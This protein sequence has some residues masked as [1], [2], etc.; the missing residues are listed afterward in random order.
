MIERSRL[1]CRKH[2]LGRFGCCKPHLFTFQVLRSLGR[3]KLR[4]ETQENQPF[5]GHSLGFRCF[6]VVKHGKAIKEKKASYRT[7]PYCKRP[8]VGFIVGFSKL[9]AVRIEMLLA[10]LV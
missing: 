10:R 1:G 2:L 6:R 5:A 4:Q 9:L 7:I 3:V 8:T